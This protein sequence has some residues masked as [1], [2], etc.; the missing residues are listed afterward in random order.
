MALSNA[1]L[2]TKATDA[3]LKSYFNVDGFWPNPARATG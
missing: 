1:V 3:I 2:V